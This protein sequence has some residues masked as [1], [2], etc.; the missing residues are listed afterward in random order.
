MTAVCLRLS[1]QTLEIMQRSASR[2]HHGPSSA[3]SVRSSIRATV[4][5]VD[6]EARR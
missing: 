6:T 5:Q 4:E 3:G 1:F 2:W